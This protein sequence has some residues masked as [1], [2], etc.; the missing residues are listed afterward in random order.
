MSKTNG[1]S[2]KANCR[3]IAFDRKFTKKY[4]KKQLYSV[5]LRIS[6]F[7]NVFVTDSE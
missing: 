5:N 3:Y 4:S 1:G 7:L 6:R 2:K